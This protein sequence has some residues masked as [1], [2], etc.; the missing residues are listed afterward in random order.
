MVFY[1][2]A[3]GNCLYVAKQLDEE[4]IS[5]PQVKPGSRYNAE[6]IGVV[7]PIFGHEIPS[8]ERA[9]EKGYRK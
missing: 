3:T 4:R 5:I 8:R 9:F 7:C 6:Q 2:T 1:F